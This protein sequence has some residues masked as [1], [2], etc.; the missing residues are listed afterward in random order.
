MELLKKFSAAFGSY[1]ATCLVCY[2][3]RNYIRFS[4]TFKVNLSK[5]VLSNN[6]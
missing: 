3:G 1:L 6:K 5:A 2:V 4:V